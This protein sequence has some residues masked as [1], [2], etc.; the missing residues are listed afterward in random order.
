[1][2]VR[3]NGEEVIGIVD[4]IYVT[5]ERPFD[6]PNDYPPVGRTL[7]AVVLG[8]APNG[9]LRLSTR[10]SDLDPARERAGGDRLL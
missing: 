8:Y 1:M 6:S 5:D 10:D 3:A 7:E 2:R 4:V 9:Q